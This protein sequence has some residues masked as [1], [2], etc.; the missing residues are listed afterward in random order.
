M[1]WNGHGPSATGGVTQ[2]RR[3]QRINQWSATVTAG[4]E[5][6]RLRAV[7]AATQAHGLVIYRA[8][9]LEA[10]LPPLRQ[11][12]AATPPR[13]VLTPHTLIAAHPG[14]RQW[15]N[16]ALAREYGAAGIAANLDILLPSAWIDRLAQ[17]QLGQQAVALPR[18]QRDRLR[19]TIHAALVG[20]VQ[21]LGVTDARI[22]AYLQT[23]GGADAGSA[24]D[25]ARRRFQLADR[26][27]GL[28]SQYLVY[29]PD[30]LRAWEQ[31]RFQVVT[32]GTDDAV[33]ASTEQHLLGPLWRH[34]RAQLGAHRGD[35]VAELLAHL[36]RADP[37]PADHAA[38]HVF[39][40]SH[41]APSELAVLRAFAQQHLVALY[42]PDPCR[43]YWGG[44][45]RELPGLRAQRTAEVARVAQA[46][47]NDYWVEQAHPLLASWGRMGQHFIMALA[48]SDGD[49]LEDVR[50]WQ[51]AQS[52]PAHDRLHRVQQSIRELR[53][54]LLE[55]ELGN[56]TAI[57]AECADASLRI[58]SCHT[59]LRE[60]EVL[61]DQLL[62]ALATPAADGA[63]I[64][65][66]DIVVMAPDI[67][68][69]VPLIPSVFGVPGDAHERLPYH[70]ADIAVARSHSLFT[71]FRRLLDLPGTRITAPE[72]VDLLALPE[73]ARRLNLDAAG[74]DDLI[75]WLR[76][77]RVAWAL[78]PAFR[79]RFGVPPIAAH[80][81]GWAMDR[82]L[83]GYLMADA[84][85]DDRQG[86]VTLADGSE[87]APLTAIHGPAA[88]NLGALNQLLATVQSLCDLAAKSL[89]ASAWAPALERHF[90]ALLRIDP[91]DRAA[92]D[93]Q[94]LLLRF[95][96]GI[97]SEPA[98]AGED[99]LLHFAVVRD[100]LVARLSAAP[101]RQRLL[102]GGIT[103]C[104]MVPQR[105]IPFQVVAVL[106]L[107][108][109]EFPRAASDSGLDLM[110]RFR[111]LGDR[112]VRTDDRYLFLET[113]MS[114]R[115]RLHLSYLGQGER[116]GKPRNPAAPLAE[117][118]ATLDAAAGLHAD[119]TMTDRPWRVR[120]P[121][122]PFDPRYFTAT[123]PRLF[124]YSAAFAAMHG[125]AMAPAVPAFLQ[126]PVEGAA[127]A[128]DDDALPVAG[129][130][131]VTL[132][133][134]AG[135]YQDPAAQLLK[136]H[137]HVSLDALDDTRLPQ[138][139]PLAAQFSPLD[140]VARKLFFNDGLA[141]GTWALEQPPAW[142][143]LGGIM[144]PGQPGV[145]AWQDALAAVNVLLDKVRS[146][147]GFASAA[148]VAGSHALDLE[149]AGWRVTGQVEKVFPVA[150]DGV[151]Q[152]QLLRPFP[153]RKG[154]L[155]AESE[156]SFKDRV[157]LF[158][159]W[160][161]LRLHTARAPAAEA[162]PIRLRAL[163]A[164]DEPRWQDGINGRDA[165]FMAALPGMRVTLLADLERRVGRLLQWWHAA[166]SVPRW[167][168][169]KAAWKTLEGELYPK[170]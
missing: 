58:H 169:P 145:A 59:R 53:P 170:G 77:S 8:S 35:V 76:R 74:L 42:V 32:R 84:T 21:A 38:L 126:P 130:P 95:I 141:T 20:N 137:L 17:Q 46:A 1:A 163:V 96:R 26:L 68:A 31:G 154:K 115:R 14:M 23:Q 160:A 89:P 93:A 127:A 110:A 4:S 108:D 114:A 75:Q 106:G 19:W 153:G 63:H 29:R 91:T 142:L 78:D 150:V 161:L 109:G 143:R 66:S 151:T 168:F 5:G 50:H 15:L 71:A 98:A 100:L 73:V 52:A 113:L 45:A 80:T 164:D 120:H 3:D 167:Y 28:F 12:L 67:Q 85:T 18:Y 83:S 132:R 60:L 139:E 97:A 49:V 88:G 119:D 121:L 27:A 33:A 25:A 118:L 30:W 136:Q 41:L 157:P 9:R 105:A 70:L 101:E 34:V 128:I 138:Q 129:V 37:A 111:R 87:L 79:E 131:V 81:F 103:F 99:P 2:A 148:P 16:G 6:D 22:T 147:P 112:D 133:E 7:D 13:H 144:P 122:Q 162:P 135:Y 40:I 117:L 64:K 116:D 47:G 57:T 152:W 56:A 146:L 134:L 123:D 155:K 69:Y 62:D 82:M 65:P 39:G 102:M 10:L 166:Q 90:E 61:R 149:V 94:T 92:R 54:Q 86:G 55:H 44:L 36:G 51:D 158:L 43:E 24:A 125:R 11:L 140:T 107:N 104:G 165:G 156:L 159:D 48:D 124:S 72:V